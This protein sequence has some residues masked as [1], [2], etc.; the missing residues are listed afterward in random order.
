MWHSMLGL[1]GDH[2]WDE[3]F[4]NWKIPFIYESYGY[5]Q[6]LLLSK[7]RSVAKQVGEQVSLSEVTASKNRILYILFTCFNTLWYCDYD[8]HLLKFECR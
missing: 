2:A 7:H 4:L 5:N 1:G 8:Y 3:W 6:R